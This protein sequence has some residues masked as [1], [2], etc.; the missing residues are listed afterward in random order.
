MASAILPYLPLVT[1]F[2][3]LVERLARPP[4]EIRA[5]H[6][7]E[8]A[9]SIEGV[10]PI[11]EL[12]ARSRSKVAGVIQNVRIDPREGS[13]SIEAVVNDGSGRMVVKW[14]G[15]QQLAGIGLGAGLIFT[16]TIGRSADG[17]CQVL[18]P[19]YELVPAPE[20]G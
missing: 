8:W 18:N 6:L 13:G 15:R 10:V 14:L 2:S 17:Q 1:F 20:H 16:G 3:D 9:G 7:R 12:E 19:E 4:Q 5:E 11:A